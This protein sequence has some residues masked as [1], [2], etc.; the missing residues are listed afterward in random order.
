L[1]TVYLGLGSN[2]GDRAAYLRLGLEEIGKL[3]GTRVQAVSHLY[4]SKPW[5]RPD[6]PDFM[7]L[8]AEVS[9]HVE[10]EALLDSCKRIEREAGR[11]P[12]ERWG[13][14]VLDVDI[15]L[16][17]NQQISTERLTV[18]HERIWERQ[19]VL[20]PLS[21]LRPDLTGPDGRTITEWLG[22]DAIKSQG[23]WPCGDLE[24]PALD[25]TT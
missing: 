6:Q 13:P 16:Y 11:T 24:S 2:L 8:V 23:V 21:D 15:L 12:G 25:G 3:P 17:G 19:F 14:R 20:Q 1:V 4:C 22:D 9:T 18:P 7:N 10:P 5:G